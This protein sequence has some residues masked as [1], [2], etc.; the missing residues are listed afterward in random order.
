MG[1]RGSTP[2]DAWGPVAGD[3]DGRQS[4]MTAPF[5]LFVVAH[6]AFRERYDYITCHLA[7]RSTQRPRLV[8]IVGRDVLAATPDLPRDPGLSPG[9]LG[10][11]LSHLAAYRIMVA[12][13]IPRA[14]VIEDDAALPE[15]FD[16]LA[17]AVLSELRPGEV[18]SLHSPNQEQNLYSSHGACGLG[19]SLLVTPMKATSVRSTLCYAIDLGAA[20]RILGGNDP[21]E[22]LPDDFAAF[23]RRGLVN[24]LRILSPSAVDLAPFESV[25]GYWRAAPAMAQVA[26]LLNRIPGVREILRRRRRHLRMSGD[27]NHV[28]LPD[29]SPLMVENPAYHQV[30]R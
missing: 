22:F 12:D 5:A 8:G 10:C 28:I 25:I 7:A 6:P 26:R 16:D 18:I 1:G 2:G 27:R 20:R 24:H 30:R 19:R 13:G 23:H 4:D 29:P 15:G 11:A 3:P 21:V 9:Q 17:R 14:V